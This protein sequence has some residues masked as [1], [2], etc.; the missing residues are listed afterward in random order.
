MT[1]PFPPAPPLR[2][3]IGPSFLIL[4]LGIGSGEVLLW[5]FLVSTHGLALAWGALLGISMQYLI[6][7]EVAR[8]ALVRGESVFTGLERTWRAA[9]VWF[10][11]STFLGFG[12]PGIAS[13]SAHVLA[14]LLGVADARWI[15]IPM[16]LAIGAI[17]SAGRSTYAVLETITKAVLLTAVPFLFVLA[18]VMSEPADWT[19]LG[20]GLLGLS[21]G[22]LLPE[23]VA[24]ATFLAAFVYSGAGGNLNLAQ[25]VYVKEKGYGM[26]AYAQKMSGLFRGDG[27]RANIRLD[28]PAFDDTPDARR[29]F[30]DWWRR[31]SAEHAVVFWLAGLVSI[32]LLMLLAYVTA[33][34][35]GGSVQGIRFV[36]TEGAV[37]GARLGPWAG[38][39]FLAAIGVVLFQTQLSITD[40]TSRIMAE[41][42]ALASMRRSGSATAPL[43]RQYAAFVWAQVA[44]GV[45]LFLFGQTEPKTLLVLG[46]FFNAVAMFVHVGLVARLNRAELPEAYRARP[47]RRALLWGVFAFL[48]CFSAVVAWEQISKLV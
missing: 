25:S 46:A 11:A 7:M 2:A 29:A 15:A 19:A 1:H 22:P 12:L 10:V 45:A 26:G 32:A 28:G 43:S 20:R 31:A 14:A 35:T 36:L 17:L 8:Y 21:E 5:P 6:N 30:G 37:I 4:A 39:A 47:W 27:G 24:L 18:L 9:P 44:F 41:N 23:G 48:G 40:A 38:S 34:G 33:Y 16:L 42:V 3:L 13:A